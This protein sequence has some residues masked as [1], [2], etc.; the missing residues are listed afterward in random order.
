M[1]SRSFHLSFQPTSKI[2]QDAI[3][4]PETNSNFAPENGWLV[5]MQVSS[6]AGPGPIFAGDFLL[7]SGRF[8]A[9]PDETSP[10]TPAMSTL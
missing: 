1:T 6:G 3:T 8:Q 2:G 10:S 7:V 5:Q 4:F 9:F